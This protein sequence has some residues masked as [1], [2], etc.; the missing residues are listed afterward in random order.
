MHFV[1][2]GLQMVLLRMPQVRGFF[3]SFVVVGVGLLVTVLAL[4]LLRGS[5][6]KA[7]HDAGLSPHG[8]AGPVR[9]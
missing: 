4:W 8:P 9:A 5:G 7:A 1:N 3:E 2:N 6:K